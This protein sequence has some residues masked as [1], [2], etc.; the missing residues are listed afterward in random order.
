MRAVPVERTDLVSTANYTGDV[1]ARSSLMVVPKATDRVEIVGG[2]AEGDRVALGAT[3]LKEGD[4]VVAA[5]A[6]A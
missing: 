5:P 1:R 6:S 3:D 2:L 4:R